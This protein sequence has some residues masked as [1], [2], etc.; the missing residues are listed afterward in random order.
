MKST[1]RNVLFLCAVTAIAVSCGSISSMQ[2]NHNTVRYQPSPNPLETKGQKI[3]VNINEA[4]PA[5]Y[6]RKD[7]VV[8]LQPVFQ[9]EGGYV[10]LKPMILKGEKVEGEGTVI[11]YKDGG[12][13]TYTDIIDYKPGMETGKVFLNPVAYKAKKVN[14]ADKNREDALKN[15]KGAI[16]L[17]AVKVAEG[18]N[19]TSERVSTKG[20]ISI[21]SHNYVKQVAKP[22]TATIFFPVNMSNLDW[23]FSINK[24]KDS[25]NQNDMLIAAVA[26]K[27]LPKEVVINGWA[28][29]E[30]EESFNVGLSKRR[31]ETTVNVINAAI[32][33]GL[34]QKAEKLGIAKND[35]KKYIADAKKDLVIS[36]NALGEDWD[37]FVTYVEA[38]NIKEKNTIVNVVKSQPDKVKREQ[39][40]RNMSFVFKELA[41]NVLPYLR[42][43]LIEFHYTAAQKSDQEIGKL[44]A[45][46]PEKLTFDELMYAAYLN[47]NNATKIKLYK[48]ATENFGSEWTAWNNAGAVSLDLQNYTEA[49]RYLTVAQKL[50]PENPTVLNN[51]GLLAIATQDFD[52]A[53][54]YFNQAKEK[55]SKEASTNLSLLTLIGGDYEKATEELAS[56]PCSYN[57]A[58][59][60]LMSGS[61][62]NAIKTL[63]CCIDQTAEV[64]YLRAVAYARLDDAAGVLEN[65]K[66][67]CE[68]EPAYKATAQKDVEFKRFWNNIEFQTIVT[69]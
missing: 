48:Y 29:P 36:S 22:E 43:G 68:M 46:T 40:I 37:N 60:Q 51:L 13:I 32:D 27:G 55:G 62:G 7:A 47:H 3:V 53:S 33:K 35:I 11:N 49:Q 58:F 67:A 2:K 15:N 66:S 34:E 21:A 57:L 25:K 14:T 17:G 5:K 41:T 61:T 64:Y 52:M 8:M 59:A 12:R 50:A 4:V 18:I 65:L 38:S 10:D 56:R 6:F 45:L 19:T 26:E 30:G 42:R 63:D 1:F 20:N 28:S 44:A 69:K 39:E 9:Y 23:N 24:E 31:A 54:N 16:S